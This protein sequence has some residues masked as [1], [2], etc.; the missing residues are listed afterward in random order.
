MWLSH[1]TYFAMDKHILK[2]GISSHTAK[3]LAKATCT[4][5]LTEL[6]MAWACS[7]AAALTST[8]AKAF[9]SMFES[10]ETLDILEAIVVLY[11]WSRSSVF[12]ML[13]WAFAILSCDI[14]ILV[15]V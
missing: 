8:L 1:D 13:D 9:A 6:R 2:H 12:A 10:S 7:T 15:F 5:A 14:D 3:T 4:V 11:C